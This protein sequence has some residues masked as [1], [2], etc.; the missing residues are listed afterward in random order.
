MMVWH[1]AWNCHN[2]FRIVCTGGKW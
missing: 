2:R 1:D